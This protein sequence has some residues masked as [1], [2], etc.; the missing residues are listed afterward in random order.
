M[1]QIYQNDVCFILFY[2]HVLWFYFILLTFIFY[3]KIILKEE[4]LVFNSAEFRINDRFL[5]SESWTWLEIWIRCLIN[6]EIWWKA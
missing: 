3:Y 2:F 6:A 1:F 5:E 4:T